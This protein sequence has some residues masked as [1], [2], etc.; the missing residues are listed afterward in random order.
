MGANRRQFFEAAVGAFVRLKAE[1]VVGERRREVTCFVSISDE[2]R[3]EDVEN[4]SAQLLNTPELASA[5]VDR[6]QQ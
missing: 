2:D 3:A 6:Y 1:N 4:W 5:F